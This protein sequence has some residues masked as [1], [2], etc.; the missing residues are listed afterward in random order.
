MI[1][2]D[3]CLEGSNPFPIGSFPTAIQEIILAT[4]ESLNFPTDFTGA[5]LLYAGSVAIGN[6]HMVQVKKTWHETAVLWLALVSPAGTTKSH[7]LTWALSKLEVENDLAQSVFEKEK[8][9]Y[10]LILKENKRESDC[11]AELSKPICRKYTV[12]DATQEALLQVLYENRRGLGVSYDE[13]AGWFKNFNRYNN[14]SDEEFWLSSWS[15]KTIQKDRKSEEPIRLKYPFISVG[16]TLQNGIL[17]LVGA[18]NRNLNGFLD[19]VL[20][21]FPSNLK[22]PKWSE[23]ELSDEIIERWSNIVSALLQLT[24]QFDELGNPSPKILKFHPE[25]KLAFIN[26]YNEN[27]DLSNKSGNEVLQGINSKLDTYTIRF[28]LILQLLRWACGEGQKESIGI[29]SVTGA[30]KLAEY[31][32]KTALKVHHIISNPLEQLPEDKKRFFE[33]LPNT[34]T[35]AQGLKIAESLIIPIPKDT[36]HKFLKKHTGSLF[37]KGSRGEYEKLV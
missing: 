16:G 5:S 14:G 9:K 31:F 25:A 10:E 2:K 27:A 17:K 13:L 8:K 20:F 15:R 33:A 22:K 29:E 4:N 28:S 19:R 30:I 3:K 37:K 11:K 18:N 12:A 36:Y 6:T 1:H 23:K 7:P 34:F 21:A 24:C 26:W 32:R 35:T